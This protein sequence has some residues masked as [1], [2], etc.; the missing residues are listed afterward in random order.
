MQ[1]LTNAQKE[2]LECFR[3]TIKKPKPMFIGRELQAQKADLALR[4]ANKRQELERI[5]SKYVPGEGER[6]RVAAAATKRQRK[7][8]KRMKEREHE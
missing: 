4:I 8:A 5:F 2:I 1:K 6:D 3:E 7:A